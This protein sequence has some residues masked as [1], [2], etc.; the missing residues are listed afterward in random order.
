M[1][2]V[3]ICDLKANTELTSKMLKLLTIPFPVYIVAEAYQDIQLAEKNPY[4]YNLFSLSLLAGTNLTCS[5][6]RKTN[7]SYKEN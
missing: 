4:S 1:F 3:V 2:S 5:L 7:V 6:F